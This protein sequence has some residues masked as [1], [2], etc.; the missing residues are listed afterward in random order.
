MAEEVLSKP[1][2]SPELMKKYQEMHKMMNSFREQLAPMREKVETDLKT[3]YQETVK[4]LLEFEGKDR[5]TFSF[6]AEDK[7]PIEVV[8]K[9]KRNAL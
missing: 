2:I 5:I 3:M 7:T 4:G 1:E 8:F 9:I 6:D